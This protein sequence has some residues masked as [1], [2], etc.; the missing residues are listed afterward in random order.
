M[1]HS[2][3][4]S[5]D[6]YGPKPTAAAVEDDVAIQ[7]EEE[8]Q[9]PA[10]KK[11]KVAPEWENVYLDQL[12]KGDYYEHSYMHRDVVTHVCVSKVNEFVMTGSADGH[13]KFWKK[14]SKTI[15][16]VKHYQA[17]LG[18]IHDMVVSSDGKLLATSSSDGMVKIFEIIGFDMSNMIELDYVPNAV[19]FLSGPRQICDRIAVSDMNSGKIRIYNAEGNA[20]CLHTVEVHTNPV[21]CMGINT[22]FNTVV[23]LD[24]RGLIEYW[25]ID[26][27]DLPRAPDVIS[28]RLK[29]E[30]GLYELAKSKTV[31]ISIAISPNG[32]QFVTLSR[33]KQI[34]VF[35]FVTGKLTKKYSESGEVY[36]V[37]NTPYDELELG[38]RKAVEREF[39]ASLDALSTAN[40]AFDETG[41]FLLFASLR[42]I[43]IV[44]LATNAVVRVLGGAEKAERFVRVAVYQ[45]V[46]RVDQQLLL[47]RAG[48]AA[49]ASGEQKTAD[50]LLAEASI[51]DPTLFVTSFKRR[52]FYCLSNR[53]PD[54]SIE[55]RDKFNEL[56]T[57]EDRL[58]STQQIIQKVLPSEAIIH[59][60]L[61]DIHIKLF[62]E[63]CPKTVENFTTHAQKGYYDN[64][65]FH[66][67][68]KGF[69]VQTGDPLGDGTGGESIWGHEFE[70]EFVRTLRHDRPFTVSMANA[71]AN[72]NGSQFFITTVPTPWL[73]NKH[74]VFGRVTKGFDVRLS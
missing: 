57:E 7:R 31:P 27:F 1:P 5:D 67:V 56:P 41:H 22:R 13:V 66:R 63:E 30:T 11:R 25:D 54:E 59:T 36:T 14:M 32:Q 23:S 21:V 18:P 65:I 46:P 3:S 58:A 33:D 12:P 19:V 64:I 8:R 71:G 15:E 24:T 48:A 62:A 38:R 2:D 43:K 17:H 40:V 20:G 61:G 26:N 10:K 44:S 37:D 68:I 52:R 42:G 29:S 73:D 53:A 74:T 69:M 72:T 60:T 35:D 39:D 9:Q 55:T 34:R 4:D 47:T 28:F 6:D 51:P 16:F 45:G 50:Q 49:G 70:D